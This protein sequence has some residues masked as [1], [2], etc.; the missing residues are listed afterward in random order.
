LKGAVPNG[1]FFNTLF[2]H[3]LDHF[4]SHYCPSSDGKLKFRETI[5]EFHK[6]KKK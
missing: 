3:L 6:N 5:P 4:D 1:S 2:V